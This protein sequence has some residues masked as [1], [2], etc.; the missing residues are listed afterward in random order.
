MSFWFWRGLKKGVHSTKYP[1]NLELAAG[2]TPGRPV[3]TDFSSVE[4]A[5]IA[6]EVCPVGA[7]TAGG[8]SANVDLRMCI[9]CQR[10]HFGGAHPAEW[11]M[12]YEW[13]TVPAG[14]TKYERLP[15][16]Y[17]RS[18]HMIVVDAGD[19]GACL[20][21]VKQLNNPFYNMH[22][23]GIF[24]TATPRTADVLLVVGPVTENMRVPL[25]K[26]YEAMPGPKRVLAVGACAVFGGIFG[27]SFVSAGGVGSV[28]PV[29]LEIPGDPPPPLAILHGLLVVTG[30]KAPV[31][32]DSISNRSA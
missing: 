24:F 8:K 31:D 4:E 22:R 25:L 30:R 29:D 21:E 15:R 13:A 32:H 20:H 1:R 27:E 9:H 10:C 11:Q 14:K 17:V 26:T 18:L 7:I 3:T 19:C 6:A 5:A 28:L 2:V 16:P 23:L 12:D